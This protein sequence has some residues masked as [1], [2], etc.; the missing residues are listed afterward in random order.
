MAKNCEKLPIFLS[1]THMNLIIVPAL[2][3]VVKTLVRTR[4]NPNCRWVAV[5]TSTRI[6]SVY[7]AVWK[8]PSFIQF[9]FSFFQLNDSHLSYQE[10]IGYDTLSSSSSNV[11]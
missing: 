11:E 9:D 5:S 2:L 4:K 3:R 1:K 6:S 10:I 7:Y 8:R